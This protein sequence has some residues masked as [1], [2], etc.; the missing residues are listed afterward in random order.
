[1]SQNPLNAGENHFFLSF[2]VNYA[3]SSK[4]GVSINL[5]QHDIWKCDFFFSFLVGGWKLGALRQAR[6]KLSVTRKQRKQQIS[7]RT[8]EGFLDTFTSQPSK[9]GWG[10]KKKKVKDVEMW[11]PLCSFSFGEPDILGKHFWNQASALYVASAPSSWVML[12]S[13]WPSF[14]FSCCVTIEPY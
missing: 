1:M 8:P 5:F 6:Q 11:E 10:W 13:V 4:I 12:N 2:S 3:P 7:R 14:V 9:S